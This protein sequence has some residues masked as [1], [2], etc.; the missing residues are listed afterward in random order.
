LIK[1]NQKNFWN[2]DVGAAPSWEAI[3][4]P[5]ASRDGARDDVSIPKVFC[6]F[7]SKNK[8]LL[9]CTNSNPFQ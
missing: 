7:F 6:F 9:F 3:G 5:V 8:R 1:K 4:W 2:A